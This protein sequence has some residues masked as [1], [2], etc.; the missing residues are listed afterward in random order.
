MTERKFLVYN[1]DAESQD[2]IGGVAALAKHLNVPENEIP[3]ARL[4]KYSVGDF[5]VYERNRLAPM[6]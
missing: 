5:V 1:K 2:E 3:T 4:W 6:E